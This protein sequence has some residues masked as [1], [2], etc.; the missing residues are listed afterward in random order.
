MIADIGRW[1][2]EHGP[3]VGIIVLQWGVIWKLL[4]RFFAQQ[5]MVM[6]A[7]NLAERQTEVA[8]KAVEK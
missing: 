4:N 7:I 6:K 3:F 1:A 8:E 5:D 2:G